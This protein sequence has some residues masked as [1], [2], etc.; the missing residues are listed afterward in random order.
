MRILIIRHAEPDYKNNTLTEQGFVE[1]MHLS[2]K[3]KN[4]ISEPTL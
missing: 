3:L 1:A 2:E 4:I